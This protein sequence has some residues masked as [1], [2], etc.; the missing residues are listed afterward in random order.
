MNNKAKPLLAVA[1]IVIAVAVTAHQHDKKVAR[2]HKEF[3]TTIKA[4]TLAYA[5]ILDKLE[6]GAYADKDAMLRDFEEKNAFE[7]IVIRITG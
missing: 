7:Q 5:Q 4:E 6:Q 2:T 3:L 1:P